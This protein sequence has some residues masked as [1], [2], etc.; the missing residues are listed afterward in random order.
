MAA[1]PNCFDVLRLSLIP[2]VGPVLG[3]RLIESL[4][5]AGE[6]V[7][8][9]AA[10]LMAVKGVGP[11][12]AERI[13]SHRDEA[14]RAADAEMARAETLGVR[15]IPFTDGPY[16]AILC[17]LPDAPLVLYVRGELPAHEQLFGIAIVGSR[18]ATAYGVEQTERFAAMLAQAGLTI[19]SGGARG[20][21]TAAH[22]AAVRV[23]GR[24]IV[25]LGCGLAHCYPPENAPLF[26]QVIGEGGALISEL[27]LTVSPAPENFPARNRIIS[28]LS[29]GTLI[30]EAPRASGALITARCAV[31]EQGR[32]VFALPGRVDSR[33]SEGA[34]EL[35]KSGAAALVT[36]PSDIIDHLE[37]QAWHLHRG[38]HGARFAP[39]PVSADGASAIAGYGEVVESSTLSTLALTDRQRTIV[40]SLGDPKSVDELCRATGLE[41]NDIAS[42]LT[43]LEIRRVVIR[44]GGKLALRR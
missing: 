44:E 14:L 5:S 22:R 8:A 33:A 12:L 37:A 30:I 6:V 17:E 23:R 31:E 15:I 4:G 21:D 34:H 29:L 26:E 24:S 20:I 1:S 35:I 27:P 28:G 10:R 40:E 41:A 13:A 25:V 42:D 16:P 19:V 3:R 11:G 32:E 2:G 38:S 9:S 36:S 7:R 43:L 39:A 18:R